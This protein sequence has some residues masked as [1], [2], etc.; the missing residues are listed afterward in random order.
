MQALVY[1]MILWIFEMASSQIIRV[2]NS[3]ITDP[4]HTAPDGGGGEFRWSRLMP[5]DST[6]PSHTWP[7]MD[8]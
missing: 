4:S 1:Q 2:L 7:R 6:T 5:V 3:W 8:I